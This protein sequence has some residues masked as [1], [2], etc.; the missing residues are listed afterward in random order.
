MDTFF[1]IL[2]KSLVV[3]IFVI[4]AFVGTYIPQNWNLV[5]VAHAGGPMGGSTLFAQIKNTTETIGT[6]AATSATAG[7]TALT[8]AGTASG[9][10]KDIADAVFWAAAKGIVSSMVSSIVSWINSG[11]KGSPAFVTDLD[12]FLLSAADETFGSYLQELGGIASFIC[13]PFS[14]DVRLALAIQYQQVRNQE[15]APTCTLTGALANIEEFLSGAGGLGSFSD[16]GGWNNLIKITSQSSTYTPYGAVLSAQAE[17]SARLRNAEGEEIALLGFG[18]GFLSMESCETVPGPGGEQEVCTITTPG[19]VIEE[20]LSFNL[21]AGQR[22]LIEADEVNEIVGALMGQLAKKAITGA[23]GLLGLSPGTGY[24]NPIYENGSFVSDIRVEAEEL[25]ADR[26]KVMLEDDIA[27]QISF[28]DLIADGDYVSLLDAYSVNTAHTDR[29][30]GLALDAIDD[31]TVIENAIAD[32]LIILNQMLATLIDVNASNEVKNAVVIEYMDSSA[33]Y[34]TE[35][36][37]AQSEGAWDSIL[38]MPEQA[39]EPIDYVALLA[40]LERALVIQQDVYDLATT[41][42]DALIAIADDDDADAQDQADATTYAQEASLAIVNT[43]AN[44][45]NEGYIAELTGL[46]TKL[47]GLNNPGPPPCDSDPRDCGNENEVAKAGIS[48]GKLEVANAAE[49]LQPDVY[50]TKNLNAYT[51]NWTAIID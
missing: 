16:N 11:F 41:S 1:A 7:F 38:R 51:V 29:A 3:T 5:E 32:N 46:I 13:S 27:T 4:F 34:Y 44:G 10:I 33:D 28:E 26:I 21:T 50:K 18:D 19:Q 24:T 2:K 15:A 9:V 23:G 17:M 37:I 12:G 39:E 45:T 47:V 49:R 6:N 42:I 25:N 48:A 8:S 31:I 20:S 43:K 14:L 36:D 35:I 40:E 30:K 22:T